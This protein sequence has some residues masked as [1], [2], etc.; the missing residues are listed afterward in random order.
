MRPVTPHSSSSPSRNNTPDA[1]GSMLHQAARDLPVP[2]STDLRRRVLAALP[3]TVSQPVGLRFPIPLRLAAAAAAT[4]CMA[5]VLLHTLSPREVHPRATGI[6]SFPT[7]PRLAASAAE[8]ADAHYAR[9]L[10]GLTHDMERAGQFL[11]SCIPT[12]PVAAPTPA[13]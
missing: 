1:L 4:A 12:A 6:P 7:P 2:A 9:E 10:Q 5:L 13:T 8:A 3:D 11:N